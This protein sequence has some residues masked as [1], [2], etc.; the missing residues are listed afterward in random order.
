MT[1]PEVNEWAKQVA[2]GYVGLN[3][4]RAERVT[5]DGEFTISEL[6]EIVGM[7]NVLLWE[8]AK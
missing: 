6:R 8:R 1:Q 4:E 5:L 2:C 7:M 3:V